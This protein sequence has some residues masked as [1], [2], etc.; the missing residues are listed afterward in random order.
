MGI[1]D[2]VNKG[3]DLAAD[4]PEKV[5]AGIDKAADAADSATGG[6]ATE[7]IEGG[8]EKGKDFVTGDDA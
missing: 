5:D 7:H 8:A 3:K 1:D 2:M 6:K 4:H